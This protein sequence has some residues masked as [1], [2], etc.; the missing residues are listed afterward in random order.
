MGSP[1]WAQGVHRQDP[2]VGPRCTQD[3]G[4]APCLQP[5]KQVVG[6]AD[7]SYAMGWG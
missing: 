6:E 5:G 1:G 2:A 3:T 4:W 7:R